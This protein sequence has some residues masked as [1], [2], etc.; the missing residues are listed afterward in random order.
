[1]CVLISEFDKGNSKLALQ[2]PKNAYRKARVVGPKVQ[3]VGTHFAKRGPAKILNTSPIRSPL[4]EASPGHKK[5]KVN[6]S[7]C[8]FTHSAEAEVQL[9]S[10][11]PCSKQLSNP[12]DPT[13]DHESKATQTDFEQETESETLK[14]ITSLLPEVLLSVLLK[15]FTVSHPWLNG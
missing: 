7:R 5:R 15:T 12:K 6:P 14:D 9:E 11:N 1:M 4:C 8:L 10:I 2:R 13:N 3:K